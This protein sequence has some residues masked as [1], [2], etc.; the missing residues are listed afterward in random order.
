MN[1]HAEEFD[2]DETHWTEARVMV[3]AG[4]R[5]TRK[6][7]ASEYRMIS[8]GDIFAMAPADKPKDKAPAFIP[9]SYN[10]HDGRTH[11]VQRERGSFVALTGDIDSG[12]HP[13]ERIRTTVVELMGGAARLIYSSSRACPGDMRWRVVVPLDHPIPFG[14]WHDAQN[15]F[16]DFMEARG[17]AMDRSLDRAGQPVFLPNVPST[18]DKTGDALRDEFGAPLYYITDRTEPDAPGLRLDAGPIADGIAAIHARRK[19]DEEAREKLKAEAERK[20]KARA[21]KLAK[22]GSASDGASIIDEFNRNND[23]AALLARY[24]YERDPASADDWRSPKQESQT[25]ATRIMGDAWVSLSGSDTAAGLGSQCATGCFGDAYDLFVHYEHG[26]DHKAA[27]KELHEERR[28]TAAAPGDAEGAPAP[29]GTPRP[30]RDWPFRLTANGVERRVE[31]EDKHTG[32]CTVEWVWFCSPLEVAADTRSADGEDWGRLLKIT[33]RDG[34]AKDWAM[35][36]A[37]LAGAGIE[38]REHLLSLGLIM[39]P[40]GFAR[41]A[42]HEYISTARPPE[43]ARAVNRIGWAS[44]AFALPRATHE[45]EDNNGQA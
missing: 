12:D 26:G 38:Y 6:R 39:A 5:D 19:Q 13:L 7:T 44:G 1:A 40:G 20:A 15:A 16:F 43:K 31:K 41:Q 2:V 32:E 27:F 29:D 10:A 28:A 14:D 35:P 30:K 3:F 25:Y 21:E 33:D 24:G 22:S 18:H 9:S 23:I 8:L 34:Q 37:M 42:L 11:A 36:M 45:E 17:I 4:Q